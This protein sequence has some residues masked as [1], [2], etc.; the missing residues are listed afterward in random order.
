MKKSAVLVILV[1]TF[2][3][4][5]FAQEVGI[6]QGSSGAPGQCMSKA[7]NGTVTWSNCG[8]GSG[9]PSGAIVIVVSGACPSGFSEE[10]SLSGKTLLGTLAANGDVGTTGGSDTITPTGTVSKPTSTFTGNQ[11]STS[12]DSAGT[13]A[14][15]TSWPASVPTFS[16]S[17][18]GTHSH[19]VG[20]YA[21]TATSAGTPAGSNSTVNFTP[22]G[23]NA[24]S[25]VSG[26]SGSEASHTHSVTAAGTNGTVNF[27]PAGTNAWPAGVPT[28]NEPTFVIVGTKMTTSGSGTAAATS[29]NGTTISSGNT[30]VSNPAQTI[31]WPAGVPTFSGTQGTVPAETFTGSGVTSGAGSSHSHGAGTYSAAA[32]TF[33]GTQGTVPAETFTGTAMATHNHTFSGSSESMSAG[34]PAGTIGWPAG[35]PAFTGNALA[36]HSHTATPSGTVNTSQPTFTGDALDNRSAFK[37]VIFCRKD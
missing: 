11:V 32:Q 15:T 10:A 17:A 16:G 30:N 22:A 36:G 6:P 33:T 21:N 19:G 7:T 29:F 37:R 4:I 13:P 23:T 35:T 8:G 25:A 12:S 18:L 9:L 1:L 2:S 3:A 27:T 24:S 5:E 34:T 31:S 26:T 28:I 14:G 20:T